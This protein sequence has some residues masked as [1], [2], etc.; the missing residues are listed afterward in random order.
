MT[1]QVYRYIIIQY[2]VPEIISEYSRNFFVL[3][4]HQN[5]QCKYYC[6]KEIQ[7]D[8]TD[9]CTFVEYLRLYSAP[10]APLRL[11]NQLATHLTTGS[12]KSRNVKSYS[13]HS[14]SCQLFSTMILTLQLLLTALICRHAFTSKISHFNIVDASKGAVVKKL[15]DGATIYIDYPFTIEAVL[16]EPFAANEDDAVRFV[17]PWLYVARHAPY[18]LRGWSS[19]TFRSE[20]LLAQNFTFTAYAAGDYSGRSSITVDIRPKK[21]TEALLRGPIPVGKTDSAV[22][23]IATGCWAN[24]PPKVDITRLELPWCDL[25]G[26]STHEPIVNVKYC[27]NGSYRLRLMQVDHKS[28]FPQQTDTVKELENRIVPAGTTSTTMRPSSY[29][30]C[31]RVTVYVEACVRNSKAKLVC[32]T[33]RFVNLPPNV[34]KDPVLAWRPPY[35]LDLHPGDRAKIAYTVTKNTLNAENGLWNGLKTSPSFKL[36]AVTRLMYGRKVY[37]SGPTKSASVQAILPPPGWKHGVPRAFD[38]ATVELEFSWEGCTERF[39]FEG[40]YSTQLKVSK[41]V[42]PLTK[43]DKRLPKFQTP[44]YPPTVFGEPTTLQVGAKNI[45]GGKRKSGEGTQLTYQWYVRTY[46]SL[47]Y[48]TYAEKILGATSPSVTLADARCDKECWSRADISG[49][50]KYYVDVC[51]TFGCRRS[52]AIIPDILQPPLEPGQAWDPYTCSY[53]SSESCSGGQTYCVK[54]NI[55]EEC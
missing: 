29:T 54:K 21:T 32:S 40:R 12:L 45:G 11:F 6:W 44:I 14:I 26:C 15:V 17:A 47:D 4:R 31:G 34:P 5:A 36:V 38:G 50:H 2:A 30:T 23:K 52:N 13:L 41:R 46:I 25:G 33:S 8:I 43:Q 24:A 49:L 22:P 16:S 53:D 18:Y 3:E 27:N 20:S 9:T 37:V 42:S 51:N 1:H 39:S 19:T 55:V 7:I 10:S 48:Q 28:W 35:Q